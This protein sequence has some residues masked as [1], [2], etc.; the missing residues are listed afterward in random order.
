MVRLHERHQEIKIF[1]NAVTIASRITD[2]VEY[3]GAMMTIYRM[4]RQDRK[5]RKKIL[6]LIAKKCDNVISPPQKASLLLDLSSLMVADNDNENAAL[7]LNQIAD[8][9]ETI[10]IPF[11]ADIYRTRLINICLT[12]FDRTHDDHI[13]QKAQDVALTIHHDDLRNR[14][15][16]PKNRIH[17]EPSPMI[18]KIRD[19]AD[20]MVVDG[21][22]TESAGILER[23]IKS[24]PDNR[25]KA[26]SYADLVLLFRMHSRDQIAKKF[27]HFAIDEA[28]KIRPLSRRAYVLCD[29]AMLLYEAGCDRAAQDLIDM[30]VDAATNIRQYSERDEVFEDLAFAMRFIREQ[31]E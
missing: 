5:E 2:P 13:K 21:S 16:D 31:Y 27:L 28:T 8:I 10:R 6:D 14:I 3:I 22:Q 26:E 25:K 9:F 7:I 19:L 12:L 30:A 4:V 20:K 1:N 17:F 23:A 11:I 18:K 15:Q 29:M 24:I